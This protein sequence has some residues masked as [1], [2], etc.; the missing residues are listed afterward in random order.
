MGLRFGELI[1]GRAQF[2]EGLII[3]ILWYLG[4]SNKGSVF[5]FERFAQM[6]AN[7]LQIGLAFDYFFAISVG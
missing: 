1:F 6:S 4:T 5:T 2:L 3:R 7:I